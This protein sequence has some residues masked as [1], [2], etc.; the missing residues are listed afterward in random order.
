MSS[1]SATATWTTRSLPGR[2]LGTASRLRP[3]PPR[4]PLVFAADGGA[5][6][7]R[8]AGIQPD[9]VVGDLDSLASEERTRLEGL[10]VEFRVSD[11]AKDESDMELCL[12]RRA[13]AGADSDHDPRRPRAWT[14]R[15][16]ASLTSCC[17][18]TRASTGSTWPSWGAARASP[19]SA[20]PMFPA[21]PII[22]GKP[23]DY[24]SLFAVG[25]DVAGVTTDGLRFPLRDEAL[26]VGP[27]AASRTSSP[28]RRRR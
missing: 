18:P 2:R 3:R 8:G 21:R 20:A 4:H 23:G 5:A 10:G 22:E 14:V 28:A 7:C 26:P 24:V 6:R 12:W 17:W 19:A 25:G 9:I 11:R 13:R 16:T 27:R 1:S 15:S